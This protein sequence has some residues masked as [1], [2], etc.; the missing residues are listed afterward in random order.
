MTYDQAITVTPVV[1][2]EFYATWCPHCRRMAPVVDELKELLGGR[3]TVLQLD[4]DA[5]RELCDQVGVSGTPLFILYRDG[6]EVW[7]H[8]GELDGNVLLTKIENYI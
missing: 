4:V 2:V 6:R 7:R 8:D 5:N 1:L 3:A